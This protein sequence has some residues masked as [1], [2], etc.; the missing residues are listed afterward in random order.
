MSNVLTASRMRT[1]RECSRKH[2]LMYRQGFRP[3][4]V[5]EPL[6]I[7]TLLHLGFA[8]FWAGGDE[9]AVL[10]AVSIE[11]DLYDRIR[12]EELLRGYV[13]RYTQSRDEEYEILSVE[14]AFTA[15]LLNPE[16]NAASR[17]WVL[18]G[19]TDVIV[20]R[21]ATGRVAVM[22]HKSTSD[23]VDDADYWSKLQIDHQISL[24]VLG[25][26]SNEYAIDDCIYDV[27]RKIG[28]RP[29]QAT[30]ADA[31]KFT[32]DGRLYAGQRDQDE[33][34]D[35]Y[36]ARVREEIEA[37]PEKYFAQ[38]N[39]P[40]LNSQLQD[41]LFDF[42][43]TGRGIREAEL[44]GR[45]PRNPEACLRFGRCPFWDVCINGLDPAEH[46]ELYVQLENVHPELEPAET[47]ATNP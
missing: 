5:S 25:A 43:Q 35:E 8:A 6:R 40:R 7:G 36:R 41:A 33:T 2:D 17:T 14:G 3:R 42:W 22:E 4:R 9:E 21:R 15:P 11:S 46:P 28:L 29:F 37:K 16:T 18:S 39:V 27:V 31:R 26:E 24:Y 32:K 44:A 1:Y 38:R 13:A 30:T 19:K 47:T 34:P 20:R 23:S 10:A 12:A 45:A